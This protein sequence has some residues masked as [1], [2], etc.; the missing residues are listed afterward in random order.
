[1]IISDSSRFLFRQAILSPRNGPAC[2]G[3]EIQA[4]RAAIR[5]GAAKVFSKPFPFP[6]DIRPLALSADYDFIVSQSIR[7]CQQNIR[8]NDNSFDF[9]AVSGADDLSCAGDRTRAHCGAP[10]G[11]AGWQQSTGLLHLHGFEPV[12]RIP[13]I[14]APLEGAPIFGA[15]D[16]TRTC[17]AKPEEPKSTEST[18]STTPACCLQPGY[19]IMGTGEC[20]WTAAGTLEISSKRRSLSEQV[21]ESFRIVW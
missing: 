11:N 12:A 15:G 21:L 8:K 18:N 1:M 14:G 2:H 4:C 20:Q 5:L 7:E 16:R 17:T 9:T 6:G 3:P 19:F 13:K 10:G